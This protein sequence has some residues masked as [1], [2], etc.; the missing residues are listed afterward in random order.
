MTL[1]KE[2]IDFTNWLVDNNWRL[3]GNG[4]CLNGDTK[5]LSSISE[6]VHQSNSIRDYYEQDFQVGDIV[7]EKNTGD[8]VEIKLV[9]YNKFDG[10]YQYWYDDEDGEEWYGFADEFEKIK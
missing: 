2:L 3:V 8:E 6:L 5:K 10:E 1:E 4:M 7:R 9:E